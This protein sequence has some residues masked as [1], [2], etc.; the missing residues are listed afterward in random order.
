MVISNTEI[1]GFFCSDGEV[2]AFCETELWKLCPSIQPAAS[3]IRSRAVRGSAPSLRRLSADGTSCNGCTDM[4][5][6][7]Q[8]DRDLAEIDT[9]ASCILTTLRT[10][11]RAAARDLPAMRT[12]LRASL[13]GYVD[14]VMDMADEAC[15]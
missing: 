12:R 2:Q 7:T 8:H 13:Q 6:P 10:M 5:I 1:P 15:S 3:A 14:L 11:H 4:P 9:A